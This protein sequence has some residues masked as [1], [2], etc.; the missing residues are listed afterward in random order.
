[1]AVRVAVRLRSRR[2]SEVALSVTKYIF[3]LKTLRCTLRGWRAVALTSD[4]SRRLSC[5]RCRPPLGAPEA[6]AG[7]RL[8]GRG[9]HGC[10]VQRI[11]EVG[12]G[13]LAVAFAV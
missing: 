12:L 5:E 2:P 13:D 9:R 3:E 4:C 11:V 1:M 6:A 7:V 8:S 10:F